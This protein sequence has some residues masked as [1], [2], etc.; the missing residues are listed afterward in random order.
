MS[1]AVDSSRA[2][3]LVRTYILIFMQLKHSTKP[4]IY[5]LIQRKKDRLLDALPAL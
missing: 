3:A 4:M 2:S 5:G 1:A